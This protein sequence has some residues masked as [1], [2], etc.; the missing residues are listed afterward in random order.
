[1]LKDA[2]AS[3]ATGPLLL[4]LLLS[5]CASAGDRLEQGLEA[6]AY[7]RWYQAANR[8]IE[9]LEKDAQMEE[10]RDRLLEVGDSAI[11]QSLQATEV[12][13]QTRDAVGAGEEY[14]R[15]DRLLARARTVGVRL[16]T[17]GDYNETRRAA[18][19]SAIDELMAL[20]AENHR[21]GQWGAGRQAFVRLRNDFEPNTDQRRRSA[22]AESHLL[23]SWAMAEEEAYRFRSAFGLAE[24]AVEVGAQGAGPDT[25]DNPI[26]AATGAPIDLAHSARDLQ[27]RAVAA[28]TVGVVVFPVTKASELEGRGETDPAQLLS[29]VLELDH[30]RL[31]PLFI[32]VA[33]PVIV[34]T[35]TRR[36]TP[37][38]TLLRPERIMDELAAEFGILIDITTLTMS[39]RNVRQ[40]ARTGRTQRGTAAAYTE[41]EG[42]LRYEVF[43]QVL[44]LD[45]DGREVEEFPVSEN[46]S[47]PF[48]RGVYE[49]DPRNLDLSRSEARLFDPVV[50]AQQ[51]AVIEDALMAQLAEG[52]ADQVF[53]RVLNRIP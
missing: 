12:R 5:A 46:E 30:W 47:G 7:G 10:A 32:A 40:R 25:A 20:G 9:A 36:I 24:E 2:L 18:F 13:L 29:D 1:M 4:T 43:A 37:P 28:G 6:E 48:Q 49:G 44:I 31:P 53:R 11:T 22:Q 17:P 15:M 34:R 38:G 35:V 14:H 27:D 42:T 23:L 52:I 39:E 8:Y 26:D 33:D 16:P 21:R 19:D 41:E 3:K 45:R 50:L 51:R